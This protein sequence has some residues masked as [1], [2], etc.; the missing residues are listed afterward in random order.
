MHRIGFKLTK[1]IKKET[2]IRAYPVKHQVYPLLNPR[3]LPTGIYFGDNF[4]KE[5]LEITILSR[6]N[7]LVYDEKL[8]SF[9]STEE[10]TFIESN[11]SNEY[12]YHGFFIIPLSFQGSSKLSEIK[13]DII[14]TALIKIY[15]FW[16]NE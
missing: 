6:G 7:A 16:Q 8:K 4:D 9:N 5:I 2:T 11:Y 15:E 10:C 12:D 3:F 1:K 14:R 13:F